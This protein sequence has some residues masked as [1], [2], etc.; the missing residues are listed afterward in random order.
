MRCHSSR[1]AQICVFQCQSWV[2]ACLETSCKGAWAVSKPV[3]AHM[4]TTTWPG[5][6]RG[7]RTMR[8]QCCTDGAAALA[9]AEAPSSSGVSLSSPPP[10]MHEGSGRS[11]FHLFKHY[12]MQALYLRYACRRAL[13]RLA[14]GSLQPRHWIAL[15]HLHLRRRRWPEWTA[16]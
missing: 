3:A 1:L 15:C 11:I 8:P 6:R 2:V 14:G 16:G 9:A 5:L 4:L 7:G 10:I 12:R 13:S